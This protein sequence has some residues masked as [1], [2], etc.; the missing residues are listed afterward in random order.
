MQV[1]DKPFQEIG[2]A[3]ICALRVYPDGVLSDV[4]NGQVLQWGDL[5]F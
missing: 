3:S 1:S 2:Q 4:V 5:R